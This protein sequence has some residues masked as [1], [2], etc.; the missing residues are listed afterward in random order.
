MPQIGVN[1]DLDRLKF[2]SEQSPHLTAELEQKTRLISV[3]INGVKYYS[4]I[5]YFCDLA[6]DA[7]YSDQ[8][9]ALVASYYQS[10]TVI[11]FSGNGMEANR[12]P[13]IELFGNSKLESFTR[14]SQVA[15]II[16]GLR[17]LID[18]RRDSPFLYR[19]KP[20]SLL[21][22]KSIKYSPEVELPSDVKFPL[23]IVNIKGGI[24]FYRLDEVNSIQKKV[25]A[26]IFGEFSLTGLIRLMTD[27][28][29][30][31][32]INN[33]IKKALTEGS[34]LKVDLTVGDIY[35]DGI[36][37]VAGLHKD[38]IASSI[39][40]CKDAVKDVSDLDYIASAIVMFAINVS[41]ISSLVVN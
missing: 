8:I 22:V 25:I 12:Q 35:G 33:I 10:E 21:T 1:V 5:V 6:A 14:H 29:P 15:G 26:S 36:H 37:Q 24:T 41:N 13:L 34:N 30:G 28:F 7:N 3:D 38:I 18:G 31:E 16:Q 17:I 40:K 27:K 23:L 20:Q 19:L 4:W 2:L 39:G 32:S 9:K 11:F